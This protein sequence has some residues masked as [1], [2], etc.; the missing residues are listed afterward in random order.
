[1]TSTTR[2]GRVRRYADLIRLV[3]RYGGPDLLRGLDTAPG[4]HDPVD[5]DAIKDAE[6]LARDLEERGPTFVKLGQ[7]LSTRPDLLPPAYIEA[8]SRLQD[9]VTPADFADIRATV[10]SELGV[11]L[12]HLCDFRRGAAG[13]GV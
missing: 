6:R 12:A 8:L 7:L 9:R 1:M 3:M 11:R 2:L 4:P 13:F 10:E 5:D